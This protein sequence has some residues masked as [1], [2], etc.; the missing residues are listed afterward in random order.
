MAIEV[1]HRVR[2][3]PEV[4]QLLLV[5]LR[6]SQLREL[7]LPTIAGDKRRREG[8][9]TTSVFVVL[10]WRPGLE[11]IIRKSSSSAYHVTFYFGRN[12]VRVTFQPTP[13]RNEQIP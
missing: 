1:V 6:R 11:R 7:E 3:R 5:A 13:S 2:G 12:S 9:L 10:T 8:V 4:H